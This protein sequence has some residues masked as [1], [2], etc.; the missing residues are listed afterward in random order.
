[1]AAP[2]PRLRPATAADLDFLWAL[3]VASMKPYVEQVYGWDDADQRAMYE[4]DFAHAKTQIVEVDGRPAGRLE[5]RA[6]DDAVWLG[7]IQLTPE[8]Q[9][10]GLG[11]AMIRAVMADAF[12]AGLPVRLRVFRINP[13]RRL[14]ERLGFSQTRETD[15]HIYMQ[16]LP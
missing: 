3:H 11:S 7:N 8:R 13:A 6:H 16:A 12:A 2:T 4:H 9:N 5:L 1:M 15:T 14:Y 10:Q